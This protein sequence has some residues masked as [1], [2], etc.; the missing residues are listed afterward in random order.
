MRLL[1]L[2]VPGLAA[3]H[4][5][6]GALSSLREHPPRQRARLVPPFPPLRAC[7]RA[8][9]AAGTP[10]LHHGICL[11]EDGPLPAELD[12][13]RRA[14]ETTGIAL[15]STPVEGRADVEAA[16]AGFD[17]IL[18]L[19]FGSLE[20]ALR[21]EG[22]GSPAEQRAIVELDGVIA[23][24]LPLAGSKILVHGSAAMLPVH[25]RLDAA[26]IL[27]GQGLRVRAEEGVA[28]IEGGPERLGP[29]W[30]DRILAHEGVERILGGRGLELHLAPPARGWAVVC[31]RGWTFGTGRTRPSPADTDPPD[32]PAVLGWGAE[33][34]VWP[35]A[36]H[37]H[38]LGPTLAGAVGSPVEK[39]FD[40]PLSF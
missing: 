15:R 30:R 26:E 31:E 18:R 36:V 16:I 10:P 7:V 32:A 35:A 34:A 5:D 38:R 21:R 27:G 37:D 12:L 14:S 23:G 1:T 11:E 22:S 29:G 2:F 24:I 4:V 17:G 9:V 40:H 20:Q 13:L 19:E 25:A 39:S 6:G 28:W 3:R 8:S 33:D